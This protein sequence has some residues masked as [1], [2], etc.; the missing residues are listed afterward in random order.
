MTTEN[1]ELKNFEQALAKGPD[2]AYEILD[3]ALILAKKPS[4]KTHIKD[5]IG[6]NNEICVRGQ[7]GTALQLAKYLYTNNKISFKGLFSLFTQ[8]GN[9][10]KIISF[11]LEPEH[12]DD[13]YELIKS[14]KM[15]RAL[16]KEFEQ[17]E[18]ESLPE[19]Y[20][21]R[22]ALVILNKQ[23]RL[24]D[25][26]HISISKKHPDH[27]SFF[28]GEVTLK[29]SFDNT[30]A[31]P[32]N[33]NA[34]LKTFFKLTLKSRLNDEELYI[35]I[36]S[37]ES[38]RKILSN[39]AE[40][41]AK[42]RWPLSKNHASLILKR[43]DEA[44]AATQKAQEQKPSSDYKKIAA[45]TQNNDSIERMKNIIQDTQALDNKTQIVNKQVDKIE[46]ERERLSFIVKGVQ[47]LLETISNFLS[48]LLSIA[49]ENNDNTRRYRRG[50]F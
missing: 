48:S 29:Q 33:G 35:L 45:S 22:P 19:G 14:D 30:K 46:Q 41:K 37:D 27:S 2:N 3:T 13:L 43:Y 24:K 28:N 44:Q 47:S 9:L 8:K 23:K 38:A 12:Q 10:K 15:A 4:G 1:I 31:I 6:A 18:R 39:I 49:A 40:E 25:N 11:G 7:K 50:H 16:L 42:K 20:P 36:S 17:E 34:V 32:L 5:S 21:V 26:K